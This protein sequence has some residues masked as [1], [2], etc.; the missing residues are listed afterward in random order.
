MP[1]VFLVL[2]LLGKH[3]DM[4]PR[5]R[6]CFVEGKII[7]VYTRTGGGNREAYIEENQAIRDMDGFIRDYDDDFDPDIMASGDVAPCHT[8]YDLTMG[9][10]HEKSFKEIWFSEKYQKLREYITQHRFSPF[11]NIGCVGLYLGGQKK[12]G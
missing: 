10:L 5:F 4:Y 11:C 7:Q 3:P 12:S 2:P 1:W 6:D 9:I 8:I